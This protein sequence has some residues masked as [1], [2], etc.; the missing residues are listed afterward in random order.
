MLKRKM[1]NKQR[2][3]QLVKLYKAIN[4]T[5][6]V[7]DDWVYCVHTT[8]LDEPKI[9]VWHYD[10]AKRV[11]NNDTDIMTVD[12]D[13]SGKLLSADERLTKEQIDEAV[14]YGQGWLKRE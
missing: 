3:K 13:L 6:R 10:W 14:R 8:D 7:K 5:K 9:S 4:K 11:E 12:V 1:T 2:I